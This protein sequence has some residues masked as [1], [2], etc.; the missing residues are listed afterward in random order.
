METIREAASWPLTVAVAPC[1][2][3]GHTS[4]INADGWRYCD[5][6]CDKQP[7]PP[8]PNTRRRK[9]RDGLAL[10]SV[11]LASVVFAL[12]LASPQSAQA[13][14][15][16]P[17]ISAPPVAP[18]MTQPPPPYCQYDVYHGVLMVGKIGRQYAG[19]L[20]S[21]ILV[22]NTGSRALVMHERA[23]ADGGDAI[24]FF[25]VW[26]TYTQLNV[27]RAWFNGQLCEPT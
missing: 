17:T 4:T 27:K 23:I 3:D 10:V 15:T 12:S 9:N 5:Q 21:V 24:A 13:S 26:H 25:P 19:H 1:G 7:L 11:I 8:P 22:N 16:P 18:V 20:V 2:D 6:F 14:G